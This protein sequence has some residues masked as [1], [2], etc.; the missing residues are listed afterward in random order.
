MPG[1]LTIARP[2]QP[3][4]VGKQN[5]TAS[6]LHFL[7]IDVGVRRPHQAWTWPS[8]VSLTE[9]DRKEITRFIRHTRQAV[10]HAGSPVR[11]C[12]E[13]IGH[14][15]KEDRSGSRV[16]LLT[17]YLNE[18]FVRLLEMFRCK[19]V[20]LDESLATARQTVEL[21]WA[22]VASRVERLTEQ[23]TV[24]KMAQRC[25]VSVSQFIHLSKGLYNRTPNKQLSR[26]RVER[27]AS[28]L[29]AEPERTVTDI[30]LGLGFSSSQYFATVCLREMGCSPSALR[31]LGQN[32]IVH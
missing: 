4:R 31:S 26:L 12:F 13:R 3:H 20:D 11:R 27:A 10:W 14:T 32:A 22:D 18:L 5:I 29:A 6:R 8:W 15:V 1:D 28:L 30:A 2:W 23:W 17:V 21:F 9:S 7:I 25:G 19:Q 16:S 24:K